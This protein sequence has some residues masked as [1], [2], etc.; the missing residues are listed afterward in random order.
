[1]SQIVLTHCMLSVPLTLCCNKLTSVIIE[2]LL[3]E[4]HYC[5]S[6]L[7]LQFITKDCM[8]SL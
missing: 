5:S 4:K 6:M 2:M 3:R 7:K 8:F 1:M